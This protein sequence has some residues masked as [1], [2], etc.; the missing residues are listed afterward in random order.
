M[1]FHSKMKAVKK[2]HI[3]PDGLDSLMWKINTYRVHFSHPVSHGGSIDKYRNEQDQLQVLRDL[4]SAL[5]ALDIF[6][7]DKNSTLQIK[8]ITSA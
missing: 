5:A 2:L 7:K 1:E 6:I 4:E 3:L 8:S